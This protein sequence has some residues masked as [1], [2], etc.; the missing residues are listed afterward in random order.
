VD[1]KAAW[2]PIAAKLLEHG[3]TAQDYQKNGAIFSIGKKSELHV[4]G[5]KGFADA[6]GIGQ[7]INRHL[8]AI[9]TK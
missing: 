5:L 4:T 9:S 2:A 7:Y 1:W 3:I 6:R 8:I